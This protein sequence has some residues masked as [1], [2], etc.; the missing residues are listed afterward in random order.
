MDQDTADAI[1]TMEKQMAERDHAVAILQTMMT[2]AF[3]LLDEQNSKITGLMSWTD[4]AP[5]TTRE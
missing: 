5:K 4:Q 1:T 3:M 2:K